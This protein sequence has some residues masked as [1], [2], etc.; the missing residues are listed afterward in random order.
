MKVLLIILLAALLLQA[1][2]SAYCNGKPGK[3]YV[4]DQPIWGSSGEQS[5][6]IKKHKY[7]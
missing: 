4:N 3:Y 2:L 6:L 5:T 1:A 7:G